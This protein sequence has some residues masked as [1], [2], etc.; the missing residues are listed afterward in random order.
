MTPAGRTVR[1]GLIVGLIAYAAVAVFYAAFDALA[2]RGTLYT[3]NLL[4]LAVFRGL[5]DPSVLQ[6]PIAP[7][8]RLIAY[9]NGV[10]FVLSLVIG[11]VVTALAD[12]AEAE[13]TRATPIVAIIVAGYFATVAAVGMLSEPIRVVLPWWS[14]VVANG[15]AVV[16]AGMYLIRVRPGILQR[17]G[18]IAV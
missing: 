9:Y 11:L 7:D 17:V 4:G 18:L 14:I 15:S 1:Q 16:F 13:P 2:A 12:R 6:L 10:H 5:R 8:F 3:V